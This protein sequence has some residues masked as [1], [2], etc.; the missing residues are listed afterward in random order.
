VNAYEPIAGISLE[1]YAELSADVA[2]TQDPDEQGR[3]VEG[4]GVPRANWE[5][6]IHGWT[7][8]MQDMSNMGQIATQYMSLYQA[9]LSRKQGRVDV[10]FEDF[11]AMEA[12]VQVFGYEGMIAHYGIDQAT[13]TLIAGHW[14]QQLSMDP[15]RYG[16]A[17][18]NIQQQEVARMRA[19]G[20]PRPVNIQRS[21]PAPQA[22]P[23]PAYQAPPAPAYQPPPPPPAPLAVGAAVMVQWADG[24][25]YPGS[26][27]QVAPDQ[28]LVSFPNGQNLWV[29]LQ[30][31]SPA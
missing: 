8:R 24:N 12:V 11:A 18:N 3:I 4:L 23:A 28:A 9:A 10:S 20:H 5:A 27:A 15:M 17:R 31:V 29:A 13:W 14:T 25:K 22:Q 6:A 1:R 21:A 19:G 7:Q 26:V 2:H 30:W 16:M